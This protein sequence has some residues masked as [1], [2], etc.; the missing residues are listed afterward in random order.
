[1]GS[2]LCQEASQFTIRQTYSCYQHSC[3]WIEMLKIH[4]NH[5]LQPNM[6]SKTYVLIIIEV[7]QGLS[8][9]AYSSGLASLIL[10]MIQPVTAPFDDNIWSDLDRLIQPVG[11][12]KRV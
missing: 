2:F 12:W 7:L 9:V 4:S 6:K 5:L 11:L 3:F 8:V 10:F 1:M